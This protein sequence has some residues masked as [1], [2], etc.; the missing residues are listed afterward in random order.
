MDKMTTA[1]IHARVSDRKQAEKE[2]SIPAQIEAGQKRADELGAVVQKTF[3]E[4]T[5]RSAWHGV[6]PEFDEALAYCELHEIDY[7]ITWD[8][9]RFSRNTAYGPSA[10]LRLR[11]AGTTIEYITVRINPET[12]EGFILEHIY[13]LTDELKS[14]KTSTDTLRGMIKNAKSGY[15]N[16]GNPPF[17][18]MAVPDEQQP[19]RKRLA[20][21]NDEAELAREIFKLK[22]H[23]GVGSRGI[24]LRLNTEGHTNRGRR[25]SKTAIGELLRNEKLTG[26]TIYNRRNRHTK[27]TNDRSDWIIV[28]SHQPIIEDDLWQRVQYQLNRDTS[29]TETGSPLSTFMFTGMLRCYCG[30]PM[31]TE[32]AKGRSRRYWYYACREAAL[33]KTHAAYRIPAHELD[34]SITDVICNDVMNE[35]A[36]NQVIIDTNSKCD[37]WEKDQTA[38]VQD[39]QKKLGI[40]RHKQARLYELLELPGDETPNLGDLTSRLREHNQTIRQIEVELTSIKNERPPVF[41]LTGDDAQMIRA[42]I[43]GW[44][45][46][47]SNP[48]KARD[49]MA[50]FI[51][52][53]FLQENREEAEIRYNP[54]RLFTLPGAVPSSVVWLPDPVSQG[55]RRFTVR[56]PVTGSR[57]A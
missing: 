5:A 36:I 27:K 44:I 32:S 17:G 42:L 24:A 13:Q 15:W 1:I 7:F 39:L 33:N 57:A 4:G 26:K 9:A 34:E 49:F 10:R 46:N 40:I 22:A 8:T 20:V 52:G 31:Q 35:E 47:P 23:H 51:E 3:I 38:R 56:V 16:G 29:N 14:R 53:I 18:Y 48:K 55:I 21:N 50:S 41:N 30:A 37:D 43:T 6:R 54:A 28:Q 2:L 25:W 11:Q 19:K 45:K 12:E